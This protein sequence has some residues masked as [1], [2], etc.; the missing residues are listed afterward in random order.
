MKTKTSKLT[1][2]HFS[3]ANPSGRGQDD[4]PALLRRV[5][6]SLEKIGPVNVQDLILHTEVTADGLRPSLTVYFHRSSAR[7]AKKRKPGK[8]ARPTT[9][10]RVSRQSRVP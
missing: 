5:S 8:V 7:R 10:S 4:I 6:K 1:A 3:Q 2:E 9:A